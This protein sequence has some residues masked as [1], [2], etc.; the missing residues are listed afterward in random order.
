MHQAH[1]GKATPRFFAVLVTETLRV[2]P[3][4]NVI[5][6]FAHFTCIEDK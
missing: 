2:T 5:D 4:V 1:L 6:F 3:K